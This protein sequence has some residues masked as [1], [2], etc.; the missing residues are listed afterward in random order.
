MLQFSNSAPNLLLIL[1]VSVGFMQGRKEGLLTGF[2]SG[3]MIDLFYGNLFGFYALIYMLSGY[4]SGHFCD[5]YY[6]ED[7]KVPLVLVAIT[8]FGYNFVIYVT[9]FLLRGRRNFPGYLTKII[10]PDIV[11]TVL[12]A[13]IFY[14]ILYKINHAMVAREKEGTKSLW[15][16]G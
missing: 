11:F 16:K 5:V 14:R 4:L 6:D 7:I 1:T 10:L 2:I 15:I 8:D 3:L 9:R 12:I 13:I